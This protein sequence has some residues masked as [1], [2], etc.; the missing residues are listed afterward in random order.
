M[1][2][3]R[4]LGATGCTHHRNRRSS[5]AG[6]CVLW[7]VSMGTHIAFDTFCCARQGEKAHPNLM[8]ENGARSYENKNAPLLSGSVFRTLFSSTFLFSHHPVLGVLR[9]N[10]RASVGWEFIRVNWISL[11]ASSPFDGALVERN[12]ALVYALFTVEE[13]KTSQIL[14]HP[15]P[16]SSV[17]CRSLVPLAYDITVQK[18]KVLDCCKEGGRSVKWLKFLRLL[19]RR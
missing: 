10:G 12:E 15:T 16:M 9:R 1:F 7:L 19:N 18:V 5:F 6:H 4:F 13:K 17:F 2:C 11:I 8:V 14:P 3:S